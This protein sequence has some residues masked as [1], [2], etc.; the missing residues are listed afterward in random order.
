MNPERRG[1]EH[2]AVQEQGAPFACLGAVGIRA[3]SEFEFAVEVFDEAGIAERGDEFAVV[4]M[5]VFVDALV[6]FHKE[7]VEILPQGQIRR[8]QLQPVFR[9][10]NGDGFAQGQTGGGNLVEFEVQLQRR[11]Q[12]IG[13]PA[14]D[15][16]E[17][18]R[19]ELAD[20]TD[21][22][23]YFHTPAFCRRK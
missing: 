6:E 10:P 8:T 5:E 11:R 15:E 3:A 16:R 18:Q 14:R 9:A 20:T 13:A 23:F 7:K 17:D 21:E 12:R 19:R 1:S 4:A 2:C 22:F